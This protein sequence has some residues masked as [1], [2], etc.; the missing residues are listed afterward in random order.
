MNNYLDMLP[1]EVMAIIYK[2][3]FQESLFEIKLIFNCKICNRYV[4][5]KKKIL[6]KCTYCKNIM[7]TNCWEELME[8][9]KKTYTNYYGYKPVIIRCKN[10]PKLFI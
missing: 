3:I 8:L 5:T 2:F 1:D 6:N 9:Y 10:C 7:C 4:N